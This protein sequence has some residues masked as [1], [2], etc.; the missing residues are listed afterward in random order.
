MNKRIR[1]PLSALLWSL[2]YPKHLCCL[3]C[4]KETRLNAQDI[5]AECGEKLVLQPKFHSMPSL[6][7]V[8]AYEY[9]NDV[10][11][12]IHRL[13]YENQR[14]L[15]EFF[16]WNI[17]R[18]LPDT[19]AVD[20]IV[21]VP[22]HPKRRRQRG[23]NQS[24]LIAD[25]LSLLLQIPVDASLLSRIRNT[26]SQTSLNALERQ[27]NLRGAFAARPCHGKHILLLD[28]VLT[29]GHTLEAC[30]Q[31]LLQAGAAFVYGAAASA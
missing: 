18:V 16:A 21:P 31:T 4:G 9:D 7:A 10:R 22:L 12:L 23:Y 26:P 25:S 1:P 3:L 28:D 6:Q 2:F 5:C 24:R 30:A 13:K 29:T 17:A 14:F 19:L 11:T 8:S 15:A 27:E 20:T